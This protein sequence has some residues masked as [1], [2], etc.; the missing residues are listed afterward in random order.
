MERIRRSIALTK[1]SLGVL[2]SDKELL[3]FPLLSFVALV[4]VLA[5]FAV[6][7]IAIIAGSPSGEPVRNNPVL[8]VLGFGF[9]IVAPAV[10]YFFNTALVGAA[11]IR[12]DG[13]DP[14]VG[15][16]LRIAFKRLPSIV[17]Y[18]VIAATIGYALRA[19][20]R[21]AGFLGALFVGAIGVSWSIATFL[22]VP[23][24]AAE[25]ISPVGAIKRSAQLLRQTWG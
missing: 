16:G 24:L 9:Y 25:G 23:I 10:G 14:S 15:D 22:V 20:A 19:I 4:V 6:P 13:G 17:I 2:R 21:R 18:A 1:A 11:L 7:I 3:V 12:L 8:L 5:I